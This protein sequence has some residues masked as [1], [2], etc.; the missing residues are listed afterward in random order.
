MELAAV[1]AQGVLEGRWKAHKTGIGTAA[2]GTPVSLQARYASLAEWRDIRRQLLGL[3]GVA[4]LR[5][6]AESAQ[7]ASLT[8]RYPGGPNEL[9]A[10]LSGRGLSLEDG[11]GGLIL[12]SGQ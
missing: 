6:E 9:A 4:D 3:P 11:A 2:Q 1:V 5:V 10:A 8:L 12:R 7:G